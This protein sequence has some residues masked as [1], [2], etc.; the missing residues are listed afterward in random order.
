[1]RHNGRGFPAQQGG[2]TNHLHTKTPWHQH[3]FPFPRKAPAGAQ[4]AREG[5]ARQ[6]GGF[7]HLQ[8]IRHRTMQSQWQRQKQCQIHSLLTIVW[9]QLA[10]HSLPQARFHQV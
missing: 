1:M 9:P 10:Q 2:G 3:P 5:G 6:R 7:H 4:H 8:D